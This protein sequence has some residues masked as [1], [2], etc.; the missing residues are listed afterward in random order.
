MKDLVIDVKVDL[1]W[2]TIQYTL[3]HKLAIK[4]EDN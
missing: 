2:C 4:R 3:V 1:I